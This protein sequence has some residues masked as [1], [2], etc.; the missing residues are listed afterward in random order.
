MVLYISS[1]STDEISGTGRIVIEGQLT[2]PNECDDPI[3]ELF[4]PIRYKQKDKM[5]FVVLTDRQESSITCTLIASNHKSRPNDVFL[6]DAI[7]CL[8]GGD[9]ENS[10]ILA[11]YTAILE[12]FFTE[13]SGLKL[14]EKA[15][16]RQD[17]QKCNEIIKN[18]VSH[19]GYEMPSRKKPEKKKKSKA[20]KRASS[21]KYLK[22]HPEIK[23]K[24]KP[25]K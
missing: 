10:G 9:S 3:V 13:K 5:L 12:L 23:R 18:F 22:E 21:E 8:K 17:Y 4:R 24:K 1:I 15:L 2:V 16:Q 14:W 19:I 25:A 11:D 6:K 20:E 7:K